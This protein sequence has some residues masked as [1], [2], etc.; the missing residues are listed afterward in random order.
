MKR[1][2][3]PFAD[4]DRTKRLGRLLWPY[5]RGQ[6]ALL[7]SGLALTVLYI[8]AHLAQPW[9]LKWL[10][11]AVAGKKGLPVLIKGFGDLGAQIALLSIIYIIVSVLSGLAEYGQNII[12]A[13]LG[14]R[15]LASFRVDLFGHILK[16]PLIFHEKRDIG[17]LLTRVVYDTARLRQ[18]VR[19]FLTRSAQTLL[20]FVFKV[21]VLFLIDVRLA[22]IL[23]IVGIAALALMRKPSRRIFRAS[24]VQRKREGRLASVVGESLTGIREFQA[25]RPD[26]ISDGRFRKLNT[27]SLKGEQK[28]RRLAAALLFRTEVLLATSICLILWL[29]GDAVKS[30]RLSAGDVVL[31]VS[32]ATGLFDPFRNFA[33]QAAQAGRTLACG[34]RLIKI[35]EKSPAIV[36]LPDAVPLTA[37]RGD[38][39][40]AAVSLKNHHARR[41]GRKW[42]LKDI[43]FQTRA[44]EHI[45]ILGPNGAGKS[46]LLKL[47]L[48]LADPDEGQIA[49]DGRDIR[50][51]LLASLR[52]PV[53]VVFQ[54]SVFFGLSVR[55]NIALGRP[56]APRGEIEEAAA[57]AGLTELIVKLADG[58]ETPVQRQGGLFSG[59]ERQKIAISR[60]LLRDGA[61][62]LLDEPTSALD[63]E[64]LDGLTGVLMDAT[65]GR[66]TLWVTHDFRILPRMDKVL[67][68]D[69]GKLLFDGTPDRFRDWLYGGDQGTSGP[70]A[71]TSEHL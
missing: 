51:Y 64:A 41:G 58:L 56:D 32:Y 12:L 50:H 40:F 16:Q 28:V 13:G 43:S 29:G 26:G 4:L 10:I 37:P 24:R 20:L 7:G 62:W 5:A 55:E 44:G 3:R 39:V 22:A 17:E 48:R 6:K 66:T 15:M 38:I 67:Y 18:G 60:A 8:A 31:F 70:G 57:R 2:R 23:A 69:G 42:I 63:A 61:L 30:G 1:R 27:K 52:G 53:S 47:L 45:A 65:K 35:M 68:L 21:V 36:D 19:N 9:P 33:R 14:N 59:G 25:F 71:K 46:T 49:I 11:D 34:D 54:E